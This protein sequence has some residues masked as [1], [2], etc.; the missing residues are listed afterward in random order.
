MGDPLQGSL[1]LF[2][3]DCEKVTEISVSEVTPITLPS[4]LTKRKQKM[5]FLLHVSTTISE[6][7]WISLDILYNKKFVEQECRMS[8]CF[9]FTKSIEELHG[10]RPSPGPMGIL[11]Q[12]ILKYVRRN[13]SRIQMTVLQ[14]GGKL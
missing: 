2:S 11:P 4:L 14:G 1:C 6:H 13:N 8:F 10:W 12:T 7:I 5:K 3:H 9:I